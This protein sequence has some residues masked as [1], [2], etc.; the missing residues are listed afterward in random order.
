MRKVEI[1]ALICLAAML[2]AAHAA[3]GADQSQ[4][5]SGVAGAM[6][7]M[8][9]KHRRKCMSQTRAF[10]DHAKDKHGKKAKSCRKPKSSQRGAAGKPT[11]ALPG[12]PTVPAPATTPSPEVLPSTPP[13]PVC[14]TNAPLPTPMAGQTTI[15]GYVEAPGGGPAPEPG[16]GSCP[17]ISGGAAAVLE[18][19]TGQVLESQI[20][21]PGQPFD[22]VVQPGEYQVLNG[23]CMEGSRVTA[24]AGQQT[25]TRV[26]CSVT[27]AK[28]ATSRQPPD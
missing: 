14:P 26:A 5:G 6:R 12:P 9:P 20:L 16:S 4:Q 10:K 11:A 22:F 25:E 15:V 21:A 1:A 7:H 8:A 18:T 13:I 3:Q 24:L 2:G 17:E 19:A 23:L 28:A 27:E